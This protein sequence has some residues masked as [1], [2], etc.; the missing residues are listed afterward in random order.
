MKN[1][2]N[3]VLL[4]SVLLV[5]SI[6]SCVDDKIIPATDLPQEIST[7]LESH[8]PENTVVQATVDNELFSKSY[9]VI[10]KDN[11]TLKFNSKNKI[12]DIEATSK[13]PNSVIPIQILDYV[14]TNYPNE[15]ITD[16]ELEDKNQQVELDNGITLEFTMEGEFLRIDS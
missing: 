9:E 8:F 3:Q 12:T 16:W 4:L 10:L 5:F 6:T 2:I 13:L 15:V 7:Y 14:K 1:Q 11:T